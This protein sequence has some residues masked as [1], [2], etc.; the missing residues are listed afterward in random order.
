MRGCRVHASK[1]QQT[2]SQLRMT[3]SVLTMN[4][5]LSW[6]AVAVLDCLPPVSKHWLTATCNCREDRRQA[7]FNTRCFVLVQ[8]MAQDVVAS[9]RQE[10]A[11]K[12]KALEKL[13]VHPA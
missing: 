1:H 11:A 7:P 6:A 9:I 4:L 13:L 5:N 10:W 12:R 2:R 3:C 8:A